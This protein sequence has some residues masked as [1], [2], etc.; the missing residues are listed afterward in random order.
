MLVISLS[1]QT[2]SPPHDPLTYFIDYILKDSGD[3]LI[4]WRLTEHEILRN[5][6]EYAKIFV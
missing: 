1:P 2:P 4:M 6:T 5:I 3:V